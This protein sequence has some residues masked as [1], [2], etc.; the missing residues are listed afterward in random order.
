[1]LF[2]IVNQVDAECRNYPF[3]LEW[4]FFAFLERFEFDSRISGRQISLNGQ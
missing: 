4:R 2:Q 1:V 3:W